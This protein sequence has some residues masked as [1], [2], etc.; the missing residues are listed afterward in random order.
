MYV[1]RFIGK[2]NNVMYVGKTV[3][4]NSRMKAH[5]T[6]GHLPI[7][8]YKAIA[9]IDYMKFKTEVDSLI[10]ETYFINLYRPYY[11]KLNKTT[12]TGSATL[13]DIKPN[14]KLYRQLKPTS[15]FKG[16]KKMFK[17]VHGFIYML[18]WGYIIYCLLKFIL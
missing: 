13:V 17:L 7:E 5:F 2:N 11:N 9:K 10:A 14:F 16:S 8:C 15:N 3:N 6:K 1:Y 18:F 4:M 12:H